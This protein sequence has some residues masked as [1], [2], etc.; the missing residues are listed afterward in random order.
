MRSSCPLRT[1]YATWHW[2]SSSSPTRSPLFSSA[3]LVL[4]RVSTLQWVACSV[5]FYWRYF[6]FSR[7]K[8]EVRMEMHHLRLVLSA[9]H[10][11]EMTKQKKWISLLFLLSGIAGNHRQEWESCRLHAH[12]CESLCMCTRNKQNWNPFIKT[13]PHCATRGHKLHR[14]SIISMT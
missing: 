11:C 2:W 3:P 6:V 13:L 1:Q 12:A 14:V 4:A 10:F 5:L 9:I 7:K 8:C